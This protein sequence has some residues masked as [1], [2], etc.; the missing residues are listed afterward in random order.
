ML[1]AA[2]GLQIILKR[3]IRIDRFRDMS[4]FLVWAVLIAPFISA[5]LA[6]TTTF[7]ESTVDYWL[8]WRVWFL[9]DALGNL[10]ITPVVLLAITSDLGWIKATLLARL[11]ESMVFVL[12]LIL[13]CYLSLGTDIETAGNFPALLYAPIVIL[14]WAALRFGTQ[15]VCTTLLIITLF[16]IWHAINSRGFFLASSA[17]DNVLSLQLFLG[18]LSI[19]MM[20][21][22]AL[23]NEKILLAKKLQI[24]KLDDARFFAKN[25]INNFNNPTI[26]AYGK[27][28]LA[29]IYS[30]TRNYTKAIKT[31]YDILAKTDDILI[32]TI[33]ADELFDVYIKKRLM[34]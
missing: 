30:R 10:I 17:T 28:Y 7:I 20:L 21:L 25:I 4:L 1:V 24:N 8:V 34:N 2:F 16:A 19:P 22:S 6:S 26:K 33:V 29:K 14:F 27:I 23:F 9:A 3:Q 5:F 18:A 11:S 31:L 15:T 13:I 12:S 32:A